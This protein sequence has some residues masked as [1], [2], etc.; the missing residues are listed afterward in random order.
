MSLGMSVA[1]SHGSP[2]S[3]RLSNVNAAE[4]AV[5]V[6]ACTITQWFSCVH[7]PMSEIVNR[8]HAHLMLMPAQ[9]MLQEYLK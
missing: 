9:E 7:T 6:V 2:A 4:L 3:L 8:Q 1:E 5:C